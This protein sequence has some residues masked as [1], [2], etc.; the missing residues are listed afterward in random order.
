MLNKAIYFHTRTCAEFG[1]ALFSASSSFSVLTVDNIIKTDL[2]LYE[3]GNKKFGLAQIEVGNLVELGTRVK[4]IN[5]G[6]EELCESK[7]P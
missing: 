7:E 6:L 4:E 2:K 5:D 1:E 3:T